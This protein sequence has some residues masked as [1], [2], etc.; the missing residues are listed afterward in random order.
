MLIVSLWGMRGKSG[1]ADRRAVPRPPEPMDR[2]P[3]PAQSNAPTLLAERQNVSC[4]RRMRPIE[5][6]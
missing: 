2:L 4:C 3:S 6:Q 5:A 1:F